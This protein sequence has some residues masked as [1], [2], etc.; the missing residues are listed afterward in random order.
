MQQK[1]TSFSKMNDLIKEDSSLLLTITR[2]GFS[3]GF[4]DKTVK[5]VCVENNVDEKTFLAVVNFIADGYKEEHI[6]HEEISI[7]TVVLY[8]RNA[9]DFFR[10]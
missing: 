6:N 2:F 1:F 5:E 8:L 3:L 9:H 7:S 4:G 10:I